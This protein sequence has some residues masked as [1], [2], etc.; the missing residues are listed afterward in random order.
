MILT[1]SAPFYSFF[2]REDSFGTVLTYWS[3]GIN[4]DTLRERH[5]DGK[6]LAIRGEAKGTWN[7]P[8]NVHAAMGM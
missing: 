5:I 3:D 2:V 8:L 6:G 4:V 1:Q 7:V